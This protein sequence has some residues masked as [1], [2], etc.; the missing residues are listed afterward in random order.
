MRTGADAL[1]RGSRRAPARRCSAKRRTA[2]HRS[3]IA[4]RS[5]WRVKRSLG[6][7]VAEDAVTAGAD[8]RRDNQEDD[9]PHPRPA[10]QQ[11]QPDDAME[12]GPGMVRRR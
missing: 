1:L 2:F 8:E 6:G 4:D 9:P 7:A 3:A 11:D 12:Q 10:A 5:R